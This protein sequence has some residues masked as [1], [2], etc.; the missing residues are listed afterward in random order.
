MLR[1]WVARYVDD[2][3]EVG[4]HKPR[5]SPGQQQGCRVVTVELVPR[6]RV[7]VNGVLSVELANRL[8]AMLSDSM[9]SG[10]SVEVGSYLIQV[11]TEGE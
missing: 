10:L 11:D 4:T 7:T 6:W 2:R 9:P 3:P 8:V 5:R 1:V